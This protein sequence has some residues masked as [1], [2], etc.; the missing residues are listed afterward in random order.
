V[1]LGPLDIADRDQ[2]LEPAGAI[3]H[4]QLLDPVLV[5]TL[6]VDDDPFN[7]AKYADPTRTTGACAKP[8]RST[9]ASCSTAGC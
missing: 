7:F 6:P 3:D 5:P 4:Q 1:G 8:R 9:S 2:A